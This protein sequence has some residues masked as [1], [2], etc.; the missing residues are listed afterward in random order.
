MAAPMVK[1]K[2]PGIYKRG[3]KYVVTWRHRG[4]QHRQSYRT[5][6]AAREAQGTR[7][8]HDEREPDS[9]MLFAEYAETWLDT[10]AGRTRRG[11]ASTSL[12]D[13]RRSIEQY[14]I[15]FFKERLIARIGPKDIKAYAKHLSEQRSG[16]RK[17]GLSPSS[18]TKNMVPLKALFADAHEDETI[19]RNPTLGVRINVARDEPDEEPRA[20][21]MTREELR[22]VLAA[23]PKAWRPFFHLLATTGLRISEAIGLEWRDVDLGVTPH[24]KLRRQHYRGDTRPLKSAHSRR[25]IPVPPSTAKMLRERRAEHYAGEEA[26]VFASR[27]DKHRSASN[28][29]RPLNKTTKDLGLGGIGFHTFRHTYASILFEA[30]TNVKKVQTLLGHHSPS[31]TLETYVHLMDEGVGDLDHLDDALRGGNGV[32]TQHPTAADKQEVA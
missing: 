7:R 31:F 23:L 13:Y 20:K 22:L 19:K 17:K 2:Y 11:I 12:A 6:E 30:G 5:L 16:K 28:L 4:V 15:P 1:T 29:R 10:Y 3:S 25:T 8:K 24:L 14:A 32:T 27:T 26:P 18:V 9:K 21:A